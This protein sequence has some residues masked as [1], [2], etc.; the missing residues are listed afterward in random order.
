MSSR[1]SRR[2]RAAVGAA[3]L[4][5]TILTLSTAAGAAAQGPVKPLKATT[6]TS[7]IKALSPGERGRFLVSC[8]SGYVLTDSAI[9]AET[10]LGSQRPD[11]KAAGLVVTRQRLR[12]DTMLVKIENQGSERLEIFVSA[13]CVRRSVRARVGG[14]PADARL[15]RNRMVDAGAA[16]GEGRGEA[17]CGKGRRPIGQYLSQLPFWHPASFLASV[18][19]LRHVARF[20]A[21]RPSSL[22]DAADVAVLHAFCTALRARVARPS[23]GKR[24]GARLAGRPRARVLV[25]RV[26]RKRTIPAHADPNQTSTAAARCPRRFTATSFGWRSRDPDLNDPDVRLRHSLYPSRRRVAVAVTNTAAG[27]RRVRLIAVCV[28]IRFRR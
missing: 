14:G 20:Q 13:R 11:I 10:V 9:H 16:P 1:Q 15:R 25:K 3:L 12:V 2:R 18:T 7:S 17:D 27:P 8:P 22:A 26:R 5:A 21:G 4:A 6:A 24:R 23:G 28:A 19:L